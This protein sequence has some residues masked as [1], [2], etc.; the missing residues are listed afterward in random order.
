MLVGGLTVCISR[1][2]AVGALRH[3]AL[4]HSGLTAARCCPVSL[5]TMGGLRGAYA[6]GWG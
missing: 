2:T 4:G 6:R 3:G 5:D 1:L